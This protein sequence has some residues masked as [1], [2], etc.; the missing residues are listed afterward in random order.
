MHGLFLKSYLERA[1]LIRP[2]MTAGYDSLCGYTLFNIPIWKN[3]N[4]GVAL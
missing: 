3:Q 4:G 2:V 1:G